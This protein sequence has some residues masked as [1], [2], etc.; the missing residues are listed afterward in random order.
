[1]T[2]YYTEAYLNDL[3]PDGNVPAGVVLVNGAQWTGPTDNAG[4]DSIVRMCRIPDNAVLIDV[5][6]SW[7]ATGANHDVQVGTS[8]GVDSIMNAFAID[9]IGAMSLSGGIEGTNALSTGLKTSSD[10]RRGYKFT[11]ADYLTVKFTGASGFLAD[12]V[13]DVQ[14]LYYI[15]A[16]MDL[17]TDPG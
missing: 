17:A 13:I 4:Q 14:V 8:A 6:L 3:A 16:G 7:T 11:S 15:D 1:M 2:T 12:A 5:L 10:I 9:A